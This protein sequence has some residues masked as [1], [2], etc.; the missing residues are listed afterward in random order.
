MKKLTLIF[1]TM[2]SFLGSWA[3]IGLADEVINPDSSAL[4]EVRSSSKGV[5]IPR[6]TTI[7]RQNISS[8]ANALLLFDTDNRALFYFD[9]SY[10]IGS[11]GWSMLNPWYF[12]DNERS[13]SLSKTLYER[14]VITHSSV[15]SISIGTQAPQNNTA[16]VVGNVAVGAMDITAPTSGLAVEGEIE[17]RKDVNVS[18]TITADEFTGFGTMPVGGIIMWSGDLTSLAGG[19]EI[20][21]GGTVNGVSIPDLSGKFIVSYGTTQTVATGDLATTYSVL[22]EGGEN[23][24][25]IT[26]AEMPNHNHDG[27]TALVA[28]HTH[29]YIDKYYET[30]GGAGDDTCVDPGCRCCDKSYAVSNSVTDTDTGITDLAGSHLHTIAVEGGDASHENRPPYY[31]LAYLIRVK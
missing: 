18:G 26:E 27:Q 5:L 13:Y 31:V 3:Q 4:V 10:S 15:S 30:G 23:D 16:T 20:C 6:L 9:S 2:C 22:D 21:D 8:P 19:W 29:T 28:N 7:E 12:R 14:D 17:A 11:A 1:L 25:T 24:D